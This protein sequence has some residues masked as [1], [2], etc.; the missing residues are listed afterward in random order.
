MYL[1]L[2]LL[3]LISTVLYI[4]YVY[5]YRIYLPGLNDIPNLL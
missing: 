4:M 1:L 5:R 2:Y 3:N